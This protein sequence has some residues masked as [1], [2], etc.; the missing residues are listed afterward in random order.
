MNEILEL[1]YRSIKRI[2][3][4]ETQ[5]LTAI[6]HVPE[7]KE[8][9][10]IIVGEIEDSY[11]QEAFTQS[12]LISL[13]YDISGQDVSY[14]QY[15]GFQLESITYFIDNYLLDDSYFSIEKDNRGLWVGKSDVDGTQDVK[16]LIQCATDNG[17]YYYN[18]QVAWNNRHVV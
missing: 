14:N 10:K 8:L 16:L 13:I 1:R 15:H 4:H 2:E 9:L 12:A 7:I 18:K 3:L 6:E 5:L 17:I 11:S